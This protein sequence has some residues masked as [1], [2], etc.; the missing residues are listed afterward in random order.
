M[1]NYKIHKWSCIQTTAT[2]F[3]F[4]VFRSWRARWPHASRCL[5]IQFVGNSSQLLSNAFIQLLF[6]TLRF[7]GKRLWRFPCKT[8]LQIWKSTIAIYRK[9]HTFLE[10]PRNLIFPYSC[11]KKLN[12]VIY[13]KYGKT[14]CEM[15]RPLALTGTTVH[16]QKHY[17]KWK[18]HKYNVKC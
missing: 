18:K 5:K 2:C 9:K 7:I 4:L 8:M 3:S 13:L 12:E 14:M 10:E 17:M 16:T 15:L 6:L 11:N 1:Q